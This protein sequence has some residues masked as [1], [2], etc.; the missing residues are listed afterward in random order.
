MIE[1]FLELAEEV[2]QLK[3]RCE[4][5]ESIN[6]DLR[7][8]INGLTLKL[9]EAGIDTEGIDI[10]SMFTN[11]LEDTIP[12]IKYAREHCGFSHDTWIWNCLAQ[13]EDDLTAIQQKL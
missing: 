10:P 6:H 8:K 1:T 9:K 12:Q 5:L 4:K 13:L 3:E 11:P 7:V 2:K